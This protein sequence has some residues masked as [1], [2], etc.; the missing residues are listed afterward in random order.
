[1][2]REETGCMQRA[3]K[4]QSLAVLECISKCSQ[5]KIDW[6]ELFSTNICKV[7]AVGPDHKG[8]YDLLQLAIRLIRRKRSA[9]HVVMF[10]DESI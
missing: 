1:M 2:D 3:G 7:G 6:P 9:L 10:F 4:H 5:K 8:S